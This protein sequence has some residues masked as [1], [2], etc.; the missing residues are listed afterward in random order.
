MGE[1]LLTIH[2]K[3]HY[4]INFWATVVVVNFIALSTFLLSACWQE[5]EYVNEIIKFKKSKNCQKINAVKDSLFKSHGWIFTHFVHC[6]EMSSWK[7]WVNFHPRHAGR[8]FYSDKRRRLLTSFSKHQHE[9]N[10]RQT[11]TVIQEP[12]WQQPP[13][14]AASSNSPTATK[15]IPV[16]SFEPINHLFYRQPSHST[17]HHR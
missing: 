5:V 8:K 2:R 6:V 4:S 10:L 9:Q 14:P 17:D 11:Q 1:K 13:Q 15:P 12:A 16:H 7:V 3:I